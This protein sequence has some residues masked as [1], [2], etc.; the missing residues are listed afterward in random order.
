MIKFREQVPSV[1]TS[2][3]RDFQYLSWLMNIVLN[4]V[5]HNVDDMYDLP[6]AGVDAKITELFAMTLGFKIKRS[7]D[8]KQLAALVVVLPKILR[9]KGTVKAVRMAAEA[10]ILASGA[11]SDAACDV[12]GAHLTIRLPKELVDITLFVD[13]LD[14]ILP[15]G[16]TC[17][18]VRQNVE[19]YKAKTAFEHTD[20]IHYQLVDDLDWKDNLSIGLSGLAEL[21]STRKEFAANFYGDNSMLNAGLL[22]NTIIPVVPGK[23]MT[24]PDNT[25]ALLSTELDGTNKQLYAHG[26]IKLR[27]KK[28]VQEL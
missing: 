13:L 15:A 28:S 7:Y 20:T 2:A 26:S 8:Q 16:M 4:S 12:D 25:V 11:L 24:A 27:A 22:S 3:S 18:V 14:Y 9:Y 10:L 17:R 23:S 19:E 6:N 5:K 1:Y 21:D